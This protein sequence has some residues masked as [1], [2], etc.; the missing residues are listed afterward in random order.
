MLCAFGKPSS[1][2]YAGWCSGVFALLCGLLGGDGVVMSGL[3][4]VS[5]P[6]VCMRYCSV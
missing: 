5:A 4:K 6:F 3:D 2:R 1:C